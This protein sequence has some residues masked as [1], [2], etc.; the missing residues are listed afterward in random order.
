MKRGVKFVVLGVFFLSLLC[1]GLYAGAWHFLGRDFLSVSEVCRRWGERPLDVAAF[2][3]WE[4]GELT[5]AAMACS[6][7]KNQDDY[8]G[9][10]G[11]EIMTLFG[12]PSGYYYSETHPAYMIVVAKTRGQDAWQIVFLMDDDWKVSEVVVHK[13]CC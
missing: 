7:L 3:S 6:L 8:V 12:E 1:A 11:S 13:N 4:W 2:R 5:R 10:D 9:M